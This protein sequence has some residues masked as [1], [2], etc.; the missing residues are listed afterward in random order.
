MSKLWCVTACGYRWV[1][2]AASEDEAIDRVNADP[3]VGLPPTSDCGFHAT[4]LETNR[5]GA[6]LLEDDA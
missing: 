3:M 4:P 2:A 1:V 5:L 6:A